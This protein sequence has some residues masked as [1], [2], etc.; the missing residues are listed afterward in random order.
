MA[1]RL[2]LADLEAALAAGHRPRA[3]WGLGLEYEQFVTDREGRPVPY[4]GPGGVES[5]LVRAGELT[6]WR[7]LTERG[8]IL[9][10]ASGDG[11]SITLEPG[12]QVEFAS[13]ICRDVAALA[14]QVEEYCDLLR[15][16]EDERGVCFVALGAQPVA[17]PREIERI[18]KARYDVLEP[19]LAGAG[20]LGIWMMKATCG[21]QV[22]L[23]HEDEEHAMASLRVA[24]G[25]APV[26]NALYANSPVRAGE[27]SGYVSWRGHVWTRTD[28]ARCGLPEACLRPESRFRDYVEWA[29]DAPM[30]FVERDGRL[31]DLRGRSFRRFLA[32][33]T[34]GL[35]A[36]LEDWRL[37][38]STL[39]PEAR[40]RPQL[41]LRSLDSQP[42]PLA[43]ALAALA[44]GI[45]YDREALAGA[46]DLVAGWSHEER[47]RTLDAAHRQGLAAPAPGGGRLLD[48]ARE[49]LSRV[50]PRAGE[51]IWLEPLRALVEYGQSNGECLAVRFRREWGGD[52]A[53][54][55][56]ASEC[57]P[58]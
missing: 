52:P 25:L 31:R 7:P 43:L 14:S 56:A 2:T 26:L 51:E 35:E 18:P 24:L 27:D 32:E 50:R 34:G 29:L 8:R 9:G 23:D 58:R 36:T 20:E 1:G 54:L 55:A 44:A 13:G 40:F 39:F 45:F 16:L 46:W 53:M 41:E 19:Y 15:T 33:G 17:A 28:P 49:L 42:P 10:L 37:H 30:L 11:R 3:A 38:L 5:I 21:L 48:L 4:S 12:A 22:N 57:V 47:L 6:G